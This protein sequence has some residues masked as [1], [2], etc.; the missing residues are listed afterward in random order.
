MIKNVI[1]SISKVGSR[2]LTSYP[3]QKRQWI[4]EVTLAEHRATEFNPK[5]AR[6][7]SVKDINILNK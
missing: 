7:K 2:K 3:S 6:N 4:Q 5:R 1:N